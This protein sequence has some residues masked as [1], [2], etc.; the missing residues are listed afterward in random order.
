MK[1]LTRL[2]VEVSSYQR[3]LWCSRWYGR[4]R[5]FRVE[6]PLGRLESVSGHARTVI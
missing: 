1:N 6:V 4:M 5:S 2:L 3:K